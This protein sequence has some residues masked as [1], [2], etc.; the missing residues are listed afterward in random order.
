MLLH[1]DRIRL[2]NMESIKDIEAI[3]K[4]RNDASTVNRFFSYRYITEESQLEW[5]NNVKLDYTE[6]NWVIELLE[7]KDIVGTLALINIDWRNRNAEYARLIINPSYRRM[8]LAFEAETLMLEYAFDYLNLHKI[9]CMAFMDNTDV[10][11]LHFKTGFK[12][13]GIY[14]DHIFRDGK[15]QDIILLEQ[16]RRF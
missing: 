2:R 12:K 5:F 15:Y 16:I 1:T 14:S 11:N 8:G 3:R 4:I 13:V 10:I 6:I 7:N 9:Y